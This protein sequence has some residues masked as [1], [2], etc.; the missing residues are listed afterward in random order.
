MR[1]FLLMLLSGCAT[2][3]PPKE[4]AAGDPAPL[5]SAASTAGEFRLADR[6]GQGWT[7]LYF[8]PKAFT[9]G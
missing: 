8:F 5:F 2:A 6:K 9:G 3:A 7:V 4:L 1:A